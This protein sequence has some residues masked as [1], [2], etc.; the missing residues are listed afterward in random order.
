MTQYTK[1]Y[2]SECL[3]CQSCILYHPQCSCVQVSSGVQKSKL[4]YSAA[5]RTVNL[6]LSHVTLRLISPRH[7]GMTSQ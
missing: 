3:D 6:T 5:L 4:T 7:N 1:I 2:K